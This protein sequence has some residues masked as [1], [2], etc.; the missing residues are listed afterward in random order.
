MKGKFLSS[1]L[2]LV[3]LNLLVKPFYILGI[4]AEV[5]NRV[6]EEVYGNYYA[7][8]NFSFLLNILL[9]LGIT[10]YNTRN[11]AQHPQLLSKHFFKILSLRFSLFLLYAFFTVVSGFLV[12]YSGEEFYLLSILMIN[13]FFVA[14]IQ[15]SRSNFAGLH[16][17]KTDA[18]IS[19]LDRGL[20]IVFCSVLLWSN[21]FHGE[22][23]IE[24]FVYAQ[25]I[26]Y[27]SSA[28]IAIIALK[29]KVGRIKLDIKKAFSI[30]LLRKSFP[31]AL[32]IFLMMMY[33]RIDA[34]MLERLLVDGVQA[35]IYAQGFRILDAVN[36]F[37]LLFAGLLLPIFARL[38]KKGE[39]IL[40][41]KSLAFRILGALSIITALI[42]FVYS[43]ELMA[44]RYDGVTALSGQSFGFLILSF[45]PV[46]LTYVYG[47]LLTANGSLKPLNYMA[48]F[49]L[50]LNV[51]L[52]LILINQFKAVGAAVATLVTQALTCVIQ[53]ILVHKL[54]KIKFDPMPFIKLFLLAGLTL[55]AVYTV[56]EVYGSAHLL[57]KCGM[58]FI[59]G[60]LLAFILQ[61]IK[62]SDIKEIIGSKINKSIE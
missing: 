58:L 52:N 19:I 48:V 39:S 17:F 4:D 26:A 3:V 24:W 20:L 37:A 41:I 15:F 49:G 54:L 8:L 40:E 56:K 21:L 5:Q 33:N 53:I 51:V 22:F 45:I 43:S 30:A 16:L 35:G 44:L 25:S 23:K 9:D 59:Y 29:T 1:L 13:Q 14:V 38:L 7:L 36:M 27:A 60:L 62:T 42:C 31:Y 34:V 12:G 18:L 46:S 28:L 10:N 57:L 11:I 47:T 6:G 61:L 2:L 32:L 50:V 55:G